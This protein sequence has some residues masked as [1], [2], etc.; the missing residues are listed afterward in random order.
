[1]TRC[2]GVAVREVSDARGPGK[3][4]YVRMKLR[5]EGYNE[6]SVLDMPISR[7]SGLTRARVNTIMFVMLV[8]V[9]EQSEYRHKGA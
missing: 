8:A 1:M 7:M 9:V 5:K 6:P 4:S 2:L 3:R